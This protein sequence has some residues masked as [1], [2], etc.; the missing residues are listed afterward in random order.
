EVCGNGIQDPGEQC[1]AGDQ[2]QDGEPDNTASCTAECKVSFCGDGFVNDVAGEE[3][4]DGGE[5]A[6][7]NANCTPHLCGDGVVN[8]TAGEQCDA[9]DTDGDGVADATSFC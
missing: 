9:G 7:C 4:D 2:D 6:A 3:C 5:S 1:D 8:I